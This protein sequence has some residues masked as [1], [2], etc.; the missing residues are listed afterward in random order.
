MRCCFSGVQEARVEGVVLWVWLPGRCTGWW[1][2][3][4]DPQSHSASSARSAESTWALGRCAARFDRSLRLP[5]TCCFVEFKLKR[6]H[7]TWKFWPIVFYSL[8]RTKKSPSCFPWK[9]EKRWPCFWLA[10]L[11]KVVGRI[12]KI[13]QKKNNL[14]I[15]VLQLYLWMFRIMVGIMDWNPILMSEIQTFITFVALDKIKQGQLD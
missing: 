9:Y 8:K 3:V 14:N 6:F 1:V 7:D 5:P 13:R 15:Q 11:I 2:W 4:D 12:C 10:S